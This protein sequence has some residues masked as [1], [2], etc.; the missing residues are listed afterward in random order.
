MGE[1]MVS[2]VVGGSAPVRPPRTSSHFERTVVLPVP[3]AVVF[4]FCRHGG[5]F[6]AVFPER[7]SAV[8][9]QEATYVEPGGRYAFRHWMWNA[10]PIRWE[11]EIH[12]FVEGEQYADVQVRGPFRY[13][14]HLHRCVP[15]G[16]GT[17]Y[18]DAVDYATHGGPALDRTVVRRELGRIFGHRQRRM[19]ELIGGRDDA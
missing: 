19:S 1:R 14:R 15:Q 17:L 6:A 12:D 5:N 9:G 10:L 16:D 3:P 8:R 13:W 2:N 4:E 18:T 11:V 7:I